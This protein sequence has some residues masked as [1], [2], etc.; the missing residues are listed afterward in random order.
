MDGCFCL[1]PNSKTIKSHFVPQKSGFEKWNMISVN[2]IGVLG[3]DR[4]V[5]VSTQ[6]QAVQGQSLQ[7]FLTPSCHILL[8]PD[9]RNVAH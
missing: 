2:K 9:S 4:L 8:R 1:T 5:S 7:D 3:P 6:R